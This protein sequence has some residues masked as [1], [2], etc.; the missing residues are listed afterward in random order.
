LSKES[1]D[2][3]FPLLYQYEVDFKEEDLKARDKRAIAHAYA[4]GILSLHD[5]GG[6]ASCPDVRGENNHPA[7]ST[8]FRFPLPIPSHIAGAGASC[9][10]RTISLLG[11]NKHPASS[12]EEFDDYLNDV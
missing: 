6:D 9:S 3:L 8:E 1:L 4:C 10:R 12:E 5:T 2:F 7:F 11:K